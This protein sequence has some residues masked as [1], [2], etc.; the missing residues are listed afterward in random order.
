MFGPRRKNASVREAK[1]ALF[2]Y[3]AQVRENG[4]KQGQNEVHLI[5]NDMKNAHLNAKCD[6]EEE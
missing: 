1:K 4:R 6:D 2:T 5:S 3:V